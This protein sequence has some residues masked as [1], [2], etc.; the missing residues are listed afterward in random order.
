VRISYRRDD[1][2]NETSDLSLSLSLSYD[3]IRT[4]AQISID[5]EALKVLS[6]SL[7]FSFLLGVDLREFT[8]E[9][10]GH[11]GRAGA[12][13]PAPLASR[14]FLTSLHRAHGLPR[15]NYIPAGAIA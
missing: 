9:A 8:L 5:E 6:L 3:R 11:H 15:R 10:G 12:S 2:F 13:L 4:I 1:R 14:L 7:S